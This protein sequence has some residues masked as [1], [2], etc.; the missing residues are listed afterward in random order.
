MFSEQAAREAGFLTML[1]A[2][3]LRL[4]NLPVLDLQKKDSLTAFT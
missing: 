3:G 4:H 1:R 2:A